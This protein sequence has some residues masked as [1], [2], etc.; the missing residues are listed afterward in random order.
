[1][2]KRI[3]GVVAGL[4]VWVAVVTVAGV[5]MRGAWRE[6]ASV[7]DAMTFTLPMMMARLS[8]G[9]VATLAAGAL[10]AYVARS[11]LSALTTG[12]VLL[13]LFIPQHIMLWTKFPVWYHLTFLLSLV[14]L[15]YLGGQIASRWHT[16]A[17][18]RS[19]STMPGAHRSSRG[20][21]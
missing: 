14:P 8:I 20:P 7:A 5:I 11:T 4:A 3:L 18:P 16:V 12:L 21:A 15:T 13:V 9:V 1:M 17:A 10:A 19:E 6:Y 2:A